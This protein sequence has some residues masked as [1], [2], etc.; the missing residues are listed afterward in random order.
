MVLA[1]DQ[2]LVLL[3]IL[4]GRRAKFDTARLMEAGLGGGMGLTA[5]L[6][7]VDFGILEEVGESV[8]V[9]VDWLGRTKR[10]TNGRWPGADKGLGS[11]VVSAAG[12]LDTVGWRVRVDPRG[13]EV[14]EYPLSDLPDHSSPS[15]SRSSFTSPGGSRPHHP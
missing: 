6:G 15:I 9:W 3:G 2:P 11:F 10:G 5:V 4:V 8:W 14:L 1:P 7:V 13:E 12:G